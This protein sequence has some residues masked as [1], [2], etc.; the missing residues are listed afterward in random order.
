MI[1]KPPETLDIAGQALWRA[2]LSMFELDP[3]ELHL[4]ELACEAR[5]DAAKARIAIASDGVVVDGRYGVRVHPAVP[6]ARQAETNVSRLLGQINVIDRTERPAR[7]AG[8]PGPKPQ[9]LR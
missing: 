4:L 9:R 2:V 6:I 3:G 7:H 5:D 8:T 1:A